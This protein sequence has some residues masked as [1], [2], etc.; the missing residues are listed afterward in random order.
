[1]TLE[2]LLSIPFTQPLVGAPK[3]LQTVSTSALVHP[4]AWV[5]GWVPLGFQPL[6][7]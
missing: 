4:G 5:C 1:M 2:D 7:G 6:W 3:L